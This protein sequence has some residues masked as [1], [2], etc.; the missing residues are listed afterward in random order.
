MPLAVGIDANAVT[1][2]GRSELFVGWCRHETISPEESNDT[3]TLAFP[4]FPSG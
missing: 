1:L 2:P 3:F 4:V